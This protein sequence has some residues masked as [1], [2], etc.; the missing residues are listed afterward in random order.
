V[1]VYFA[2]ETI[3]MDMGNKET[4]QFPIGLLGV[5]I[6]SMKTKAKISKD[7]WIKG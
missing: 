6:M 7:H 3:K 1:E 4:S 2:L 5:I